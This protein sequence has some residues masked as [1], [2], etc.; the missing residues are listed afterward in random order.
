MPWIRLFRLPEIAPTFHH[1]KALPPRANRHIKVP[2]SRR[3]LIWTTLTAVAILALVVPLAVMFGRKHKAPPK[4]SVLV[5]LYVYP[6]PGAW[7]PLYTV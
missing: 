4:V 7:D 6:F 3:T 5:P 2:A 1:M